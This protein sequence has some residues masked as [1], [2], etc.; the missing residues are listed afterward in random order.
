MTRL[1]AILLILLCLALPPRAQSAQGHIGCNV[2]TNVAT[3]H[4][5]GTIDMSNTQPACAIYEIPLLPL[6]YSG[7]TVINTLSSQQ[8]VTSTARM[9]APVT[10][11]VYLCN[12]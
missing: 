4:D 9:T 10:E 6:T 7:D 1:K 8:P 2:V 12:F 11:K 5:D 3:M